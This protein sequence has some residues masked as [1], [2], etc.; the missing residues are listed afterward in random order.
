[1]GKNT[2]MTRSEIHTVTNYLCGCPA[3][4]SKKPFGMGKFS[5]CVPLPLP[6]STFFVDLLLGHEGQLCGLCLNWTQKD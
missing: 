6:V 5:L 2:E 3:Y 4:G 1:M